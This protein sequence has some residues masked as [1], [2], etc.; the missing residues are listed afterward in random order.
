MTDEYNVYKCLDN[1]NNATSL[2]KPVGTTVDP[3]TMPDGYMWKYMYSIPIALRNKFLTD[4]YMP[5]VTA[6]RPQF[7]SSGAIQTVKIE[8]R[9]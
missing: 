9:C 8:K 3:V 5:V 6:L 1:N 4:T 7:Y 2:F